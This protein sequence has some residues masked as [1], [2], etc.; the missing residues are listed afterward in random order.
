MLFSAVSQA[1]KFRAPGELSNVHL[2]KLRR[3]LTAK[4]VLSRKTQLKNHIFGL[5]EKWM[6]QVSQ[7]DLEHGFPSTI[8]ILLRSR[9]RNTA[10]G[11]AA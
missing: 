4:Y 11:V 1:V 9:I 8:P 6:C 2:Y 7:E 3:P 5:A 10:F